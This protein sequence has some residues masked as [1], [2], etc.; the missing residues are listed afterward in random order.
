M[1]VA[2][3]DPTGGV[4]VTA[5]TTVNV[6]GSVMTQASVAASAREADVTGF[7]VLKRGTETRHDPVLAAE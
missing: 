6:P 2:V 5:P 4:S 3:Q 1:S 7:V